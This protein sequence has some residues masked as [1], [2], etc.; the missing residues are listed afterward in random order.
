MKENKKKYGTVHSKIVHSFF[1]SYRERKI[2]QIC[3]NL[4]R[5]NDNH[6]IASH[7]QIVDFLKLFFY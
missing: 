1:N 3:L 2:I 4:L 5:H 7:S 6:N